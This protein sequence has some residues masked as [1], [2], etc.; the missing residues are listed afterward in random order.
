MKLT[1]I[2][3]QGGRLYV[4]V[5]FQ[6]EERW[7]WYTNG[8]Q[9][10]NSVSVGREVEDRLLGCKRVEEAEDVLSEYG[11]DWTRNDKI[12]EVV[13]NKLYRY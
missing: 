10:R 13:W 9:T 12:P 8:S 3:R 4:Y 2:E 7:L 5:R 1:R 6:N 11:V